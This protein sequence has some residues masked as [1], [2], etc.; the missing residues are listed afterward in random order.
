MR[1]HGEK[2]IWGGIGHLLEFCLLHQINICSLRCK[3]FLFLPKSVQD[4]E[5]TH[6]KDKYNLIKSKKEIK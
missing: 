2:G 1:V 4:A 6:L 3:I 5:I